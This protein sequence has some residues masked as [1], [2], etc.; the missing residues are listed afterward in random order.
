MKSP[1]RWIRPSIAVLVGLLA[2]SAGASAISPGYSLPTKRLEG[3]FKAALH[4]RVASADGCYPRPVRIAA[5]IR[6]RAG[7]RAAVAADFTSVRRP[8]VVYVLKRGASCERVRLALRYKRALFVLDS[9]R[10]TVRKKGAH[11]DNSSPGRAG[12]LSA[13]AVA[14]RT[15]RLARS[16]DPKRL[17]VRCPAGT[18]PLGGGMVT[19]PRPGAGGEAVYPHSYERLGAQRGWHI[20]AIL[21]DHTPGDT[22]PRRVRVQAVCGRGV[23]PARP[24][25][26]KTVFLMPGETR[27]AVARC[28]EG[29][30]LFSGGFQR[31]DFLSHGGDFITESRAL[32]ASAWRVT[33]HAFGDFGG[34]LTAIAY[35][36]GS[37][38]PL[39]ARV[40]ASTA[41]AAGGSAKATTPPCPP[42]RRLTAGG[43]SANG[44]LSALF[45]GGSLNR[46]GT[47]SAAGFGYFGPAERF[48]AYGYCLRT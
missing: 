46:N 3:A 41:V 45:A 43:F 48:T 16:D 42:G 38:R 26:H 9:A 37:D 4:E 10:G 47:W 44:S 6:H 20:S 18:L 32:G 14:T 21:L 33:A 30:Y 25:P 40:S 27:T 29:Q 11:K 17:L 28:P 2:C 35:C 23:V 36:V 34:E 31:T 19:A 15:F 39:L 12:P 22:T 7:L 8:G 24:T 1:R 5:A 13:L